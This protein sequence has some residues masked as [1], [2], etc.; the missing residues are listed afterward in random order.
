[1]SFA[2]FSPSVTGQSHK[3]FSDPG[4]GA[5]KMTCRPS[6][7]QSVGI[8]LSDGISAPGRTS[9]S[10]PPPAA[11]FSKNSMIP[12]RLLL[13]ISRVPSGDQNADAVTSPPEETRVV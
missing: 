9:R 2:G 4:A 10:L 11:L 13:N 8:R 3:P 5:E 7:D 6:G 12:F 1:M